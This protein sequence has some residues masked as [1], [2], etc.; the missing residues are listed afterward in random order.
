LNKTKHFGLRIE[1]KLLLKL[2]YIA[3]YNGRSVSSQ[4]ACWI[5]EHIADFERDNHKITDDDLREAGLI[6]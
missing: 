2:H 5:R 3:K 6:T 1:S 4:V